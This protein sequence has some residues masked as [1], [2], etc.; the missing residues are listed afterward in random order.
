[1]AESQEGQSDLLRKV[2]QW[3]RADKAFSDDWRKEAKEDFR[4][5]A[6]D[7]WNER[8]KAHLK[9]MMRPVITF[10]R[11]LPV[12]NSI[13]GQEIGNRQEVR[14]IPRT[15][16]D[17]KPNELLTSSAIW[18]RDLADADDEDSEAF[19][20]SIVSG[21]GW[22]ET[23]LDFED[24]ED[25]DPSINS[26]NPLEMI[27]DRNARKKNL[28]DAERV[29]RVR[30]M[31]V[32]RAKQMFPDADVS[33]MDAKWAKI[34]NEDGDT[35]DQHEED[36]YEG[37]GDSLEDD[38]PDTVVTIVHCQWR[39]RVN[40]VR[41][42][43]WAGQE[44][45]ME[46]AEFKKAK[47]RMEGL[48]LPFAATRATRQVIQQAWVGSKVLREN[49]ALCNTHFHYQCITAYQDKNKGTFFGLV[50][51]MKDPQRW[52]NKWLSQALDILNSQAKGG[53]IIERDATDDMKEFEKTFAR[54][55]LP[56]VVPRGT[57]S[58][59]KIM[60]KP[61]AQMPS[62]FMQLMEFAISS[63]RDVTGVSVEMLGMRE[64]NQPAS[65]EYQRR[66]AGMTIMQPL[67]ANLKRYRHDQ[68]KVMLYLIQKY[69]SDGRLVRVVG[70]ENEQFVPLMKQAEAAYD[71]I[72][73][74][75]PTSPNQ[76]E[77]VWSMMTNS[78]MMQ[79][80]PPAMLVDLLEYSPLP[81]SVVEKIK[82][83]SQA[84]A[85][86]PGAQLEQQMMQLEA[87]L[88]TAEATLKEA[89]AG[90]AQADTQ[91]TL[92]GI[93]TGGQNEMA[94]LQADMA[95]GQ[96]KLAAD[97]G[98]RREGQAMDFALGKEQLAQ[99]GQLGMAD[100]AMKA[101]QRGQPNGRMA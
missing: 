54:A 10:N 41:V 88:K 50:H 87:R 5:V 51:Q 47:R 44:T 35:K 72:V 17:V 86:G 97:V 62:G 25:G 24:N 99:K 32:A 92:A 94:K 67:F 101:M 6:G 23:T 33:D 85:E 64:A 95:T 22:T 7:Q 40:E 34:D 48:G 16:G 66:Q 15:E 36:K 38:K 29:Y 20:N 52:A 58:G 93:G 71:I 1:M 9:G 14:F 56:T 18:F 61:G 90:K 27:W 78:G 26:V 84:Q 43:D 19:L 11:I 30:Q 83:T 45:T 53:V 91:E 42:V 76:K 3:Y 55:D 12:I 46:P 2:K 39:D 98:L 49:E 74:D 57:V 31:A 59:N 79:M 4:F 77:A 73:D 63:V 96:Q 8:D 65:L 13:S 82:K 60:P 80:I 100:M 68:G 70:E 81:S 37:D 28:T 89:Q 21:M 75:Q 69:L